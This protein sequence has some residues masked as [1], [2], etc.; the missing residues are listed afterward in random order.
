MINSSKTVSLLI[1]ALSAMMLTS[2]CA[3][4]K[5]AR[6][7][8]T[9]AKHDAPYDA[10]IVTGI[11]Y[12]DSTNSGMIYTARIL[13]SK[14]LFD[15][16]ITKNIIYSGSAVSTPYYEGKAMKIVADSLGVPPDHTFAETKAE[17][18]TENVYYGMKMAHKLGFKK[19]AV[20]ADPFQVKMLK[21]FLKKRCN[22]MAM[23]P[24]VYDSVIHDKKQWQSQLPKVDYTG[25]YAPN[26][27]RL[28]DR[29][30]FSERFRGTQGKHIK[31][32]E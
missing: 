5:F 27:V 19:L 26:F 31:F 25:A 4:Q 9:K 12:T 11:P 15:N 29:E 2:A 14:Y 8:Y 23:I 24:I 21:K 18:S 7:Y 10:I 16:H 1:I 22:N 20:A 30:S 17:H 3:G 13:W 28:S 6:K 32:E